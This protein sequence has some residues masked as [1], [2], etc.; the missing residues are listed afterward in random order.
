MCFS[1]TE[2]GRFWSNTASQ[3]LR[4]GESGFFVRDKADFNGPGTWEAPPNP[5]H[6]VSDPKHEVSDPKHEVSHPA[7]E[8]SDPNHL[9]S[10]PKHEVSDLKNEDW[11]AAW[12]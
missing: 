3:K 2:I 1:E 7:H 6:E 9:V 5:K 12:T 11:Q 10:D 8:V 4:S